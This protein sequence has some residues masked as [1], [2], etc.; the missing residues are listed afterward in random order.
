MNGP[1]PPAIVM[2]TL[3]IGLQPGDGLG[4]AKGWCSVKDS[5]SPKGSGSPKD[6]GSR[7]AKGLHWVTD[8]GSGLERMSRLR[9]R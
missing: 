3:A 8:S 5:G 9:R 7:L 1:P 4:L 6:S 2:L